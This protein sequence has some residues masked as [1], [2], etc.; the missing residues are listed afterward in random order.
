MFEGVIQWYILNNSNDYLQYEL[1]DFPDFSNFL[2]DNM[3][4][5]KIAVGL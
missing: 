5:L 1:G 2:S 4:I 3:C